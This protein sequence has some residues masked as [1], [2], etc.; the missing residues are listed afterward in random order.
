MYT[1]YASHCL[2]LSN[3]FRLSIDM[4]RNPNHT[5]RS[6]SQAARPTAPD[7]DA[8]SARAL[9]SAS[10]IADYTSLSLAPPDLVQGDMR[11]SDEGRAAVSLPMELTGAEVLKFKRAFNSR[12]FLHSWRNSV[13]PHIFVFRTISVANFCVDLG[14]VIG[15]DPLT[16]CSRCYPQMYKDCVD[17]IRLIRFE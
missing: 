17:E 4:T 11:F 1:G 7:P 13:R 12:T 2:R 15:R 9:K 14:R 6:P 10:I 5:P 16:I 8:R 3:Q